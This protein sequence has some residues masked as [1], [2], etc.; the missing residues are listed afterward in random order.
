MANK[1]VVFSL[2]TCMK[3]FER[4]KGSKSCS[5]SLCFDFST[6]RPNISCKSTSFILIQLI[7]LKCS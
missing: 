4:R 7:F 1:L 3:I 5:V 2:N 6:M